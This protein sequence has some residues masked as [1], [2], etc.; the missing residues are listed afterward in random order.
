MKKSLIVL[1]LFINI[2]TLFSQQTFTISGYIKDAESGE[3]LIAANILDA[4]TLKGSI[5][6]NYGFYSLTLPA[7]ELDLI[8]SYIGYED[9]R[10]TIELNKD[11][12]IN[13]NLRT[14]NVL[15]EVVITAKKEGSIEQRTQMSQIKVNI[16]D[17]ERIPALLGEV[18]LIKALQ[19]LPGV[20]GGAEG[21]N[22]MYVRG[23]SPDQNLIVLDGVP[24]YNVSHLFGFLSVFNTDAIKNV[25]LTKGGFPARYG[26]RLS[27]VLEINMKEGNEKEYHG[28]GSI[29]ILSS[30]L[31]VEGPIIKDKSSFMISGR[32]N[33]IDLIAGPILKKAAKNNGEDI[34]I[35]AYFYD[36][37]MKLNYRFNNEHTLYLSSY[38]G[39]DNFGSDIKDN[40]QD[41][42][43]KTSAGIKWGN[44]INALRWNWKLNSKLFANTTLTYSQFKFNFS[45]AEE[46]FYENEL[47][48][49]DARYR[50]GI[51]DVGGKI[52]FD[53]IPNP[54][55]YIRFG[56]GNTYHTYNPGAIVVKGT[57]E[58]EINEFFKNQ[59]KRYSN[60][61]QAYVEDDIN[62]GAFKTNIGL[63]FSGF[64][65]S[66][67]NYL[68]LQP[69]L[70]MRY[71]LN[72]KLSLKASYAK[73]SQY[74]NL[75][76]NESLGLPTDLWVPSTE[77]IKPQESQQVAVGL[78]ST[79]NN[80][81]EASFETYYKTMDNVISYKEGATF[82]DQTENWED[83]ITQG[84]GEAY[85][86]EFLLEKKQGKLTGWL[87]YT[88]SWNNRQFD[89]IN[90]GKTYP[91]KFDRR[92]D[93]ELV[94]TYKLKDNIILNG[95]W[96][97]GT[98]NA[99]TLSEA[100]YQF[101]GDF[102]SENVTVMGEKNSYRMPAYH[103]MDLGI[104]F[105]KQKK[106][107]ERAWNISVYNAYN[108]RNPFYIYLGDVQ[109]QYGNNYKEFRQISIIPILPS[110]SYRFKF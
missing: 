66:D 1:F 64:N 104:E 21:L 32:R 53:F 98:G 6:N 56:L 18:D 27:S 10:Q 88:L 102:H 60:E 8:C 37:N 109:D 52:D 106:W 96:V 34:D 16:Q 100:Q 70:G 54:T 65:T 63:H 59:T 99:I 28:E 103:R 82:L 105:I 84:K 47:E 7:G 38:L 78:A 68:S 31:T 5:S 46:D 44:V 36:L 24:V 14:A 2:F 72:D 89:E 39:S 90:F 62:L 12:S 57:Y 71:L 101:N 92:H 35:N 48:S 83:K 76:T 91:Y 3:K 45:A 55:H 43:Y 13:F 33:Y 58:N 85:G 108:H 61:Y 22:G 11:L 41:E 93:L 23:G 110:F 80:G 81:L 97:Y 9:V 86:A 87:G 49:Y 51:Y 77:R 94:T 79:L 95:S 15:D 17:I 20:Q 69:R 26:G 42:Y 19:L 50:S 40:Y 73:M 30:R 107:G 74:I 25:S 67:T 29:G 75:L 4:N